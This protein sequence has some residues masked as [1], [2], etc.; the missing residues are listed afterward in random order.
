M[1]FLSKSNGWHFDI[2][3]MILLVI[4]VFAI[5]PFNVPEN[6]TLVTAATA[7]FAVVS[8]FFIADAMA[9]YLT[10]QGLIAEENSLHISL[11][12]DLEDK[13]LLPK[14]TENIRK[15]IDAYLIAQLDVPE[16]DH[17]AFTK[18]EFNALICCLHEYIQKLKNNHETLSNDIQSKRAEMVRINQ[19][20][21]LTAHV[22]LGATH[23]LLLLTLACVVAITVLALRDGGILMNIITIGM[24]LG[25]Q[26]VLIVLRDVD[27]NRFLQKKLAFKNPQQVF[28]T[29]KR[30]PYYPPSSK[31]N[32]RTPNSNGHYRIRNP[33]GKI[34]QI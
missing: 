31:K 2:T 13:N 6:G 21:S 33:E 32:Q 15:A 12:N 1:Y 26:G 10:L 29:L 27:N 28:S 16:L 30:P 4:V 7:I 3:I 18:D 24:L 5:P 14:E 22:N 11:I 8:G 20:I 19:E 23:W 25:T 34:I 17:V 9:N